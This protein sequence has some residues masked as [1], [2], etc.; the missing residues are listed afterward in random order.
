M[1][2]A[3]RWDLGD[4]D[5]VCRDGIDPDLG[6]WFETTAA[7]FDLGSPQAV[8]VL[9]ASLMRDGKNSR[10]VS[11]DNRTVNWTTAVCAYDSVALADGERALNL[12]LNTY[13]QTLQ[14]TPPDGIGATT[15]FVVLNGSMQYDAGRDL[16][17]VGPRIKRR[18]YA[19]T[20]EC[21]PFGQATTDTVQVF[22]R[23]S[24]TVVVLD[25]GSAVTDWSATRTVSAVTHLS[26]SAIK[27]AAGSDAEVTVTWSG[28]PTSVAYVW[29]DLATDGDTLGRVAALNG[30][31]L[32]PSDSVAVEGQ[33]TGYARYFFANPNPG[34]TL[35]FRIPVSGAFYI[36]GLGTSTTIPAAGMMTI[37]PG[38]SAR[39]EGS[40]I[41]DGNAAL[42]DVFVF[43]DPAMLDYGYSPA[44]A[45]TW[46][47]APAGEYM[48][49]ARFSAATTDVFEASIG[50]PAART[51]TSALANEWFPVGVVNLG[52]QRNGRAGAAA[53]TLSASPIGGT[54]TISGVR[55]FRLDV[56][57]SL[58]LI[59]GHASDELVIDTPSL[60][61]P[62]GGVYDAIAATGAS[63]IADCDT[64]GFPMIVP[65]I[66]T[67]YVE[68]STGGA[69]PTVTLTYRIKVHTFM[70]EPES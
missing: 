67:L 60:D 39:T 46:Q 37:F 50:S 25:D 27:V 19:V 10:K 14:W 34:G 32:A 45:E 48:L 64:W 1:T 51:R 17:E 65:P 66:T 58:T 55:L 35:T 23:S 5:L 24:G 16:E 30:V 49:Y 12:A 52:G 8:K 28:T 11:D 68:S 36:N 47:N 43:S 18:Y 22:E 61:N 3:H 15:E 40:L 13:R 38:G 31:T 54:A 62:R 53:I 63:I 41:V 2:A 9:S 56:D 21:E 57:T 26:V 4:L 7:G 69:T 70:A 29:L 6:Y 44:I 42:D 59:Q 33:S 20:V